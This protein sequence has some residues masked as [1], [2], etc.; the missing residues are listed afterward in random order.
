MRIS[1]RLRYEF[2]RENLIRL[3]ANIDKIQETIAS[4]RRL[5]RP[6]DSPVD[7]SISVELENDLRKKESYERTLE[8]LGILGNYYDSS[9]SKIHDLLLR[10][11]EIAIQQGSDTSDRSSRF[12]A[13]EE[14]KGIIEQLVSIGNTNLSGIYIFSGKNLLSTP[15]VLNEDY[16]V[17]YNGTMGVFKVKID[18]D[19]EIDLTMSGF[20][21]F[22]EDVDLFSVLKNFKEALERGNSEEIRASIGPIDQA[23]EKI[24]T[25]LSKAGNY[26]S[27][28]ERAKEILESR[29][30]ETLE[31][32]SNI[33][34]ADLTKA[35]SDFQIMTLTYQSLLYSMAKMENLNILNYLR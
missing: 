7:F 33:R 4:G 10:A 6:K 13:S 2:L 9:V 1:D 3:K 22:L 5:L 12:S 15:F 18:D 27:R 25:Y 32:L 17:T 19:T 31:V 21:V 30:T 35:I 29:K 11:K 24:E 20:S 26:S 16:S 23:L 8:R 28:I 14:I 34:D